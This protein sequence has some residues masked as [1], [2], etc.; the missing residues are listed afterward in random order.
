[1]QRPAND[2]ERSRGHQVL[3]DWS[4]MTRRRHGPD[5]GWF[6]NVTEVGRVLNTQSE[7]EHGRSRELKLLYP[8][9]SQQLFSE[10]VMAVREQCRFNFQVAFQRS[11]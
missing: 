4:A 11:K 8:A 6:T 7:Q 2:A 1:M 9:T 3:A 5:G 10:K